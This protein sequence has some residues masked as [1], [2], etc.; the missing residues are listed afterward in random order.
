L[1]PE[2]G[3]WVIT[4]EDTGY[5]PTKAE[6]KRIEQRLRSRTEATVKG[7]QPTAVLVEQNAAVG[8]YM[9]GLENRAK[10]IQAKGRAALP[11]NMLAAVTDG[12]KAAM[13]MRMVD[14]RAGDDKTK[15]N[16]AVKRIVEIY[17]R[18]A[19]RKGVQLVFA[20][21]GTPETQA[22]FSVYKDLKAKLIKAGIPA[23]QIAFVHDAKNDRERKTQFAK[24]RSGAIRVWVASTKKG[25]TG[26]DVQDRAAIHNLDVHW[27]LANFQ[28]RLGVASGRA[29]ST[30]R[31]R[32][33]TTP[34]RAQSTPSCGT[35]C[36]PRAGSSTRS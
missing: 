4:T 32:F 23:G 14:P 13:D 27:N 33:S 30:R 36:R 12:R 19:K 15:T 7:G 21:L 5:R 25:G 10:Y 24:V 26:V 28:Q 17:Q 3:K 18:E 9:R 35:R 29:T 6:E 22:D 20:D 8:A 34:P 1:L 16:A 11:D 2:A 31:S